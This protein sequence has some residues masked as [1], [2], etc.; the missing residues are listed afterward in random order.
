MFGLFAPKCPLGTRDKAWVERRMLWLADRFGLDRLRDAAVVTPTDDF[1][2]DRYTPDEDGLE[3]TSGRVCRHMG[4]DPRAVQ[5]AVA[6][7]EQLPDAAGVYF[8]GDRSVIYIARRQL[9]DPMGLIATVAHELAHEL[10]LKG[11]HL[12][13]DT[14]DHEQVT[15]LLPVFLGV[16]IFGANATV[17]TRAWRSGDWEFFSASKQG[18]L[19]ALQLGYALAVF[20]HLRGE[21]RPRWVKHLRP[22]AGVTMKAALDYLRKTN[23]CLFHPT[24]TARRGTPA[25][26]VAELADPSPTVRLNALWDAQEFAGKPAALLAAVEPCLKDKDADVRREAV[27]AVGGF[28][29]AAGRLV[30]V[31]TDAMFH[32]ADDEVRVG[33]AVALGRMGLDDP[34]NV[35][36]AL[37]SAVAADHP[38]LV[39]AAA[40]SLVPFGEKAAGGEAKLL[41]AL[42][43]AGHRDD[44]PRV[45]HLIAALLAA[46]P[47]AAAKI[48]A[49]VSTGDPELRRVVLGELVRQTRA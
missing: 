19:S 48:K 38:A 17:R 32:A 4:V 13:T 30:P 34:A 33:A 10:L 1:F 41:A 40:G 25:E 7:D 2:P 6:E 12:T 23:D 44:G 43:A 28:G 18:Y 24:A 8:Q 14:A 35:V 3:V 36:P 21:H 37:L 47:D 31:L 5:F 45:G 20:A 11:G 27:R 26:L 39:A 29:V 9:A 16:G 15:D 42:E 22:D 49:S 46:V